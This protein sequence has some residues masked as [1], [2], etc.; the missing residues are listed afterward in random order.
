MIDINNLNYK[1]AV[2]GPIP[3]DYIITYAGEVIE[4]YGGINHPAIALSKLLNNDSTI[5]PVTHVRRRDEIPIKNILSIY[6]NINLQHISSNADQGD[7]I[8][9]RF[10]DLNNRIEKQFAFMNPITPDDVKDL[11]DCDAFVIVPVTDFEVTLDTLKFIKKHSD[12]IVIFDAH[13]PTSSLSLSGDRFSKFWVDRD[14]WLP[15]IDILK[16]NQHEAKCSWFKKEYNLTDLEN[17][18]ALMEE[19]LQTFA[20]HCLVKGIKALYI[21]LD[22]RGCLVYFTN[23]GQVQKKLI[24]SIKMEKV[25]DT[26][27]CGDSF[28][29]GVAFGTLVFKDY[30]KAAQYGNALGAQRTQGK[31]FDVFKSYPETERMVKKAYGD[32]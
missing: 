5:I 1:I 4:K 19:E 20:E 3:R 22:S 18:N 17:K 25:V 16:M 10:L 29:A 11:L 2:L 7:V 15:Y 32:Y 28:A 8:H 30:I 27:G 6:P 24:S 14:C 13:G 12:A 9:L 21:T 23:N 26:T 31:T